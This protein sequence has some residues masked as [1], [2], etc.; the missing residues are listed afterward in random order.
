M[1]TK[2]GLLDAY[3]R[4]LAVV[5]RA[6]GSEGDPE[7]A[8]VREHGDPDRNPDYY[9]R[10]HPKGDR[11]RGT[12][13]FVEP[14]PF[15]GLPEV[16]RKSVAA[17][18]SHLHNMGFTEQ[19]PSTGL[20]SPAN[21]DMVAVL[22]ERRW[23]DEWP[24]G[25]THGGTG[26]MLL[27]PRASFNDH[28]STSRTLGDTFRHEYGHLLWRALPEGPRLILALSLSGWAGRVGSYG[29]KKAISAYAAHAVEGIQ[30]ESELWAEA[31]AVM[32]RPGYVPGTLPFD[33][34][35]W[36][37]L[38]DAGL[39]TA[40]VREHGD[41]ERMPPAEYAQLHPNADY[42]MQHRAPGPD[43]VGAR[44][45][46][47]STLVPEDIYDTRVQLRHYGWAQSPADRESFAVINAVRGKPDAAV[48]I[49]RAVPSDVSDII[50][51]DW[52]TLSPSYAREHLE[53]PRDG[54]GHIIKKTVRA[55]DLW[56][57]ANSVNEFGYHPSELRE[58]G[59]KA[60]PNYERDFHPGEVTPEAAIKALARGESPNI[61][62]TSLTSLLLMA[63]ESKVPL[64]LARVEVD[65]H[66]VFGGGLGIP[67]AEMPSLPQDYRRGFLDSLRRTAAVYR[68]TIDPRS[69]RPLQGEMDAVK[70]GQMYLS[71]LN[72]TMTPGEVIV[73][74]DN[75]VLDGH[76][77]WAVA[78]ARTFNETD[79][80]IPVIRID[81]DS[82]ELLGFA[83]AYVARRG[84]EA[85]RFGE[86]RNV[87]TDRVH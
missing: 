40:P 33:T 31:F 80:S 74:R 64:D 41:P 54:D 87:L 81:I 59:D 57:D 3:Q 10:F 25:A 66:E 23:P 65:G 50:V 52:V 13:M 16:H 30:P 75:F 32:T 82:D 83:R 47:L 1:T 79:V 84:I 20:L 63:A 53:G 51:G 72:G 49:Y 77:R 42:R 56:W 39:L 38:R 70:I 26:E 8:D 15:D 43:D 55:A 9:T 2:P 29:V 37:A 85:R 44:L 19:V 28:Y 12:G 4:V 86:A 36:K 18:A 5:P 62:A 11:A 46:D 68:R 7:H 78:I 76:H 22:G 27:S 35:A 45:D 14:K 17:A 24:A 73:T 6:D 21:P 71:W 58:H 61:R 69:V 34:R 67:R 48:T 60:D